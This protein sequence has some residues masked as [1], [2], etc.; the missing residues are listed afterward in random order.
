[1]TYKTGTR[2]I[3]NEKKEK[4]EQ[5]E[6]KDRNNNNENEGLKKS[7][8]HYE[9]VNLVERNPENTEWKCKIPGCNRTF[10]TSRGMATHVGK[11]HVKI[12]KTKKQRPFCPRHYYDINE[13]FVHL[14]MMESAV[15]AEASK[16]K[17]KMGSQNSNM[18]CVT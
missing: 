7:K 17:G 4:K 1:M 5:N 16:K 14:E 9:I 15:Q 10:P 8:H 13:L 3:E 18:C 12:K 2:T 6:N 11:M